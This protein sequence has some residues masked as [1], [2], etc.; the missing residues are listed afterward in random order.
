MTVEMGNGNGPR[1]AGAGEGATS[2]STMSSSLMPFSRSADLAP[3]RS[4]VCTPRA[5][6]SRDPALYGQHGP[7][8]AR[9]GKSGSLVASPSESR[10]RS[11]GRSYLHRRLGPA[12]QGEGAQAAH[13]NFRVPAGVH[14]SDTHAL[15]LELREADALEP[16]H[17]R[18][19]HGTRGGGLDAIRAQEKGRGGRRAGDGPVTDH[20]THRKGG[21]HEAEGGGGKQREESGGAEHGFCDSEPFCVGRH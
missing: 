6:R 21:R 9:R 5:R 7:R 4:L 15:S 13:H 11:K 8:T 12:G 16:G 2:N 3:S 18:A 10:A 14:D 17:A 1:Q 19:R 20:G